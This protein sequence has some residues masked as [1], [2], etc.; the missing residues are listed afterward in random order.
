M[1]D[2]WICWIIFFKIEAM[3]RSFFY[4]RLEIDKLAILG[5]NH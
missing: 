2:T 5:R 3:L 1:M 4:S